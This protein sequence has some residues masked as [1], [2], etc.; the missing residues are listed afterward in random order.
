M[1]FQSETLTTWYSN[2]TSL[3]FCHKLSK[4]LLAVVKRED[5]LLA[6]VPRKLDPTG[7]LLNTI[8]VEQALG[9]GDVAGFSAL[10]PIV[11]LVEHVEREGHK[12][13]RV[14]VVPIRNPNDLPQQRN[15]S[16]G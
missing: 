16:L 3:G 14:D 4:T 13:F 9:Q 5:E 11:K 7:A 1:W 8:P 12:W 15:E 10:K 6:T 2:V